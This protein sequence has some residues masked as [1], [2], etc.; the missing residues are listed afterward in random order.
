M[1]TDNC[2]AM[3]EVDIIFPGPIHSG[4]NSACRK[5]IRWND[6]RYLYM[7]KDSKKNRLKIKLDERL[8]HCLVGHAQSKRRYGATLL[9][10]DMAYLVKCY[11]KL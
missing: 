11:T 10:I 6:T 2:L 7:W 1:N 8:I 4:H 9:I 3:G 5:T